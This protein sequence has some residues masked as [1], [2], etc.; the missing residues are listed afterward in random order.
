MRN[1]NIKDLKMQVLVRQRHTV[2]SDVQSYRQ[3][4]VVVVIPALLQWVWVRQASKGDACQ[5]HCACG[6]GGVV[7]W[8]LMVA[9]HCS[10]S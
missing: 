9:R 2:T 1:G 10:L 7:G 6:A 4:V 3:V 8:G 5:Y